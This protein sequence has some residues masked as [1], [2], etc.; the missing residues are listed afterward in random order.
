VA[1]SGDLEILYKINFHARTAVRVLVPVAAFEVKNADE[2]YEKVKK[3]NWSKHLDETKTFSIDAVIYSENFGHSRFA[4]Y[5]VKDAIVD[6]FTEKSGKRPS[7]R[8]DNPDLYINVHIS[9]TTCT[10]SLD[11]SGDSLHKR[12]YRASQTDAPLNEVLAAGMLLLAG[13]DGQCDF[14]DPMCGSG[15]LLTEAAMIAL[16]IPP[17]L[18]RN[19]FAF[20]KWDNFDKELFDRIYNDESGERKFNFHIYGS[21]NSPKAIRIAESNIKSAGL[22]KYITVKQCAIQQLEKPAEKGLLVTNPPYGERLQSDELYELYEAIGERLKHHFQGFTAWVISSERSL[23]SRI[24]LKP[25]KRI[26][27]LNS[28]LECEFWEF[29]LFSGKRKEFKGKE[30]FRK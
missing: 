21:D 15:T 1:C 8:L 28:S 17:G 16:N 3:I 22:S 26:P 23:L 29:E 24:G 6:Q 5:R 13:W 11:S 4:T 18:Y 25:S 20:E 19:S 27:L 9:N 14:V 12:G 30:N 2:L 7:I 10:I